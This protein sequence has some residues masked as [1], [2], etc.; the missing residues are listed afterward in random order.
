[1]VAQ[2]LG[3][4]HELRDPARAKQAFTDLGAWGYIAFIVAYA[5]FQ[6]FG[7]PGTGFILAASLIWP[8]PIAFGLSMAGTMAATVVG[9]SVLSPRRT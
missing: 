3:L 2:R 1:V 6:P 4:F 7:L 9:F 8:W 5:L